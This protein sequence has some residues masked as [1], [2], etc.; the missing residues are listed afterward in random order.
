MK[1][2]GPHIGKACF[3][4]WLPYMDMV[5]LNTVS[6]RFGVQIWVCSA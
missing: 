2:G 5:G 4:F 1:F 6:M 3:D